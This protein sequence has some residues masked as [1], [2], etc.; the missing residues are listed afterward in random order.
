[1]FMFHRSQ[2]ILGSGGQQYF[3]EKRPVNLRVDGVSMAMACESMAG[4][5]ATMWS[6]VGQWFKLGC[7]RHTGK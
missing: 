4:I 2:K 7:P 3:N 6:D 1:M 5:V